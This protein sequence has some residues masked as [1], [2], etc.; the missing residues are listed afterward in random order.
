MCRP[1][2]SSCFC[3]F[4]LVLL[5]VFVPELPAQGIDVRVQAIRL[6]DRADVL[7]STRQ[8]GVNY[9][10]NVT[11]RAFGVDGSE[12]D[13]QFTAIFSR[14]IVRF[15]TNFGDYHCVVLH[16]PDKIVQGS[17]Y[18]P[19]PPEAMEMDRLTPLWTGR[20]DHSDTIESIDDATLSGRPAKCIQFETVNGRSSEANQI[21]IDAERGT[22]LR[23]NVGNS[24]V[25][26]S[27]YMQ[28]QG[29]WLP[30]HIEHYINGQLRM[31]IDQTFQVIDHPIDWAS[32]TPAHAVTLHRCHQY[33]PAYVESE[34]QPTSA[35]AGPWYNI[36]VHA[37]V[38]QDGHVYHAAVLPEGKPDLEKQAEQIVSGWI[39]SPA[40]C[41]GKTI[42]VN[43]TLIV[44]FPPQ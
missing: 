4:L 32:L 5:F 39:F 3:A 16:F 44:H 17:Q 11:F 12:K 37:V 36:T 35:G 40:V 20:F 29:V 34:P 10:H 14:G 15:E 33:K 8:I 30:S 27:G 31:V 21:C 43:A 41:N 18:Q 19:E 6:L 1:A 25:N 9:E 42:P 13:G 24:L 28:F 26:D 7:S 2:A 22:L 23:W 38:G